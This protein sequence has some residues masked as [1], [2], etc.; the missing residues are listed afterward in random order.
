MEEIL[1]TRKDKQEKINTSFIFIH[2]KVTDVNYRNKVCSFKTSRDELK[3]N[4]E[5]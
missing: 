4:N 5:K 1:K 2:D 3:E